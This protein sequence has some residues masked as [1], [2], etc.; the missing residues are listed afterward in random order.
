MPRKRTTRS[1]H[2]LVVHCL[3]PP[4]QEAQALPV[5]RQ[6]DEAAG[7]SATSSIPIWRGQNL[8]CCELRAASSYPG[9]RGT[10]FRISSM[11]AK[12]NTWYYT[13]TP[14]T[15]HL[16]NVLGPNLPRDGLARATFIV[17]RQPPRLKRL[18]QT[19][20]LLD[21]QRIDWAMFRNF[22]RIAGI[23]VIG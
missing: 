17:H 22:S 4:Q 10:Y 12:M 7:C 5:L 15:R 1:R 14:W 21:M 13:H 6:R 20:T 3:F 19:F 8:M 9:K 16:R 2:E 23:C 18:W 11:Q